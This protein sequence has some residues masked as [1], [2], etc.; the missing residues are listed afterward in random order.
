MAPSVAAGTPSDARDVIT[1]TLGGAIAVTDH[2]PNGAAIL[3]AARSAYAAGMNAEA[4]A[5][6]VLMA[7]AAA[8]CI[9]ARVRRQHLGV[10]V[11]PQ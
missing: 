11:V 5:G 8:V 10:A 3:D 4:L 7:V 1:E 2:L 6:A 9:M